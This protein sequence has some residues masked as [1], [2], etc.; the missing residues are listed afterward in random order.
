MSMALNDCSHHPAS[1][2]HGK[3]QGHPPFQ[4]FSGS[5]FLNTQEGFLWIVLCPPSNVISFTPERQAFPMVSLEFC[6]YSR[7]PRD[8]CERSSRRALFGMSCSEPVCLSNWCVRKGFCCQ[9]I[10]K[11]SVFNKIHKANEC[12]Q[13]SIQT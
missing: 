2:F 6:P 11:G 1:A 3:A 5:W 10:S 4:I 7:V 9:I 8:Q 13:M 12:Q